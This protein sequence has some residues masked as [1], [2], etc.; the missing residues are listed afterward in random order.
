MPNGF[1]LEIINDNNSEVTIPFFS[2]DPLPSG[3]TIHT[4]N[5]DY[6]YAAL[7]SIAQTDGFTGSGIITDDERVSL[8]TIFRNHQSTQYQFSKILDGLEIFID[9]KDNYVSMNFP[10]MSTT[11]VQ[12]MPRFD[13]R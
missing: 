3:I 6:T 13:D 9:G 8:L 1:L 7:L 2:L 11:L 12:L 4:R 5:T 10:P